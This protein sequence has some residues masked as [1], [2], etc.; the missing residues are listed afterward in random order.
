VEENLTIAARRESSG[1]WNLSSVY[2]TFPRIQ[3]RRRNMGL[4]LSG[5]E[6]QM[7]AIARALMGNPDVLLM[8]EPSEGLAPLIVEEI[9]RI[10]HG[11]KDHGISILLVEQNLGVALAVADHHLILNKGQIAF[12]CSSTELVANEAALK[13]HL[14]L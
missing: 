7:L 5:G 8:D 14:T 3:E 1:P 4:E 12:S 10:I 9:V 6:Q 2:R 11:L 13:A